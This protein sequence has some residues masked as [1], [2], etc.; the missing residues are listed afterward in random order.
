MHTV[1]FSDEDQILDPCKD[2][3]FK[4]LFTRETD[5]A[6]GALGSLV[7]AYVGRKTQILTITANEPP[8]SNPH[9]RQIRYDIT[10]KLEGGELANLEM[11]LYPKAFE[12][13]R[14]EYHTARLYI[15]QN[16]K[17][18]D[19][20]FDDL[21]RAY[22]ISLFAEKNLYDDDAWVH[23]FK[24]YDEERHISLGGRTEI[25]TVELEKT[26]YLLTRPVQEMTVEERWAL[27][28]RY[29]SEKGQRALI[30]ELMAEEEGIA[31]AGKE[32]LTVTEDERVQAWLMSAEKYE[33]DV[34]SE[35]TEARRAGRRE[36]LA[37]GEAKGI[38]EAHREMAQKM[39]ASGLPVEQI[40]A[41]T[42]LSQ[43]EI[44]QL[45]S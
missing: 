19:K 33:L 29:G 25:I 6:R 21:E 38:A 7:S 41:F 3:I 5:S 1:H 9:D 45:F 28:F 40:A 2:I 34:Q 12:A 43:E 13:A 20:S 15:N 14:L 32:L 17:G 11:T 30:N 10:C 35:K 16:I 42:G 22:Q 37:E 4:C 23:H 26:D 27:F 24:Y 18:D 44:K 31:M 39:K 8:A 36:G